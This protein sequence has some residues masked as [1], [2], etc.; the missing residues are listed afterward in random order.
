[1]AT[2]KGNYPT[3]TKTFDGKVYISN[4]KAMTKSD[5]EK[6]KKFMSGAKKVHYKILKWE[7][8]YFYIANNLIL[9]K[10]KDSTIKNALL[11]IITAETIEKRLS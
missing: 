10:M 5:V 1:M 2:L 11:E 9:I 4:L 7:N 8:Y 3:K 6:I